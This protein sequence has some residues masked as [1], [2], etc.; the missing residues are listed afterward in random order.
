MRY[1]FITLLAWGSLVGTAVSCDSGGDPNQL[2]PRNAYLAPA[3]RAAQLLGGGPLPE[4]VRSAIAEEG[5]DAYRSYVDRLTDSS[6]NPFFA[7]A[8]RRYFLQ[9]MELEDRRVAV[10]HPQTQATVRINLADGAD[11]ATYLVANDRPFSELL[12]SEKCVR[13]RTEEHVSGGRL[14]FEEVECTDGSPVRAGL[15]TQHGFLHAMPS[16]SGLE[17]ARVWKLYLGCETQTESQEEGWAS[18]NA[19]EGDPNR[20]LDPKDPA[21]PNPRIH[22]KYVVPDNDSWCA[23]CHHW[24]NPRRQFFIK[25]DEAGFYTPGRT[26]FDAERPEDNFGRC[27]TIPLGATADA[28]TPCPDPGY[29]GPQDNDWPYGC[30][31]DPT[32]T[33]ANATAFR[34][35]SPFACVDASE[36]FC[37]GQYYGEIF[38]DLGAVGAAMAEG[39][40]DDHLFGR[41]ASTRIANHL[42]G[43]DAG[44]FR[45]RIADRAP[46]PLPDELE[47]HLLEVYL[48]SGHSLRDVMRALLEH[49][50]FLSLPATE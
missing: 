24:L 23:T 21:T 39:Q 29:A 37:A 50:A 43:R 18:C 11:L 22:A 4:D 26:L 10:E 31:Y 1:R 41:C 16:V 27:I 6:R 9:D 35:D 28:L 19:C 2:L 3:E 40:I 20:A 36:P 30:C 46:A 48:K 47:A 15:F 45:D 33:D 14:R 7:P 13:A 17:R 32:L 34:I 12:T 38:S 5:L 8:V 42:L 44:T 25:Y 49:P